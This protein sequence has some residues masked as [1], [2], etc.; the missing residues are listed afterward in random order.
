MTRKYEIAGKLQENYVTITD[1]NLLITEEISLIVL[2][3]FE[4]KFYIKGY[5]AYMYEWTPI[6]GEVLQTRVEPENL[7]D[8]CSCCL[9]RL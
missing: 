8:K 3:E 1:T 5:Q 2:T 9:K 6:V 4:M 7:V